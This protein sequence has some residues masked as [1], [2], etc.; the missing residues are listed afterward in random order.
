MEKKEKNKNLV[1]ERYDV[2]GMSCAACELAVQKAVKKQGVDD[3]EVSLMTNSMEVRYDPTKISS[4]MIEKAVKDAGYEASLQSLPQPFKNASSKEKE[5]SIFAEQKE[6]IESRLRLSVPFLFV[7]MYFSMGSMIGFPIPSWMQ[8]PEGSSSFALIQL[9]LTLP[10]L[11]VNRVFFVRGFSALFHRAPN[12]DSLIAL[13]ASAASLYG[14]FALF[15]INYGLGFG[16][17]EIVHTYM[18]ELYFEGA[19]MICTL[20]TVGKYLEV[21]SKMKTSSSLEALMGLRPDT[22]RRVVE[23]TEKEVPV[24]MIQVGDILSVK[25]GERI[26]LDG[27]IIQGQ[28]SV[29]ESALTGESLPVFK[30]EGD[31]VTGATMNQSGSFLFRTEAVGE[32]TAL[33]K[34]IELVREANSSKAPIQSLADQIAGIFVPAVMAISLITFFSWILSGAAF[35]FAL[36]LAISVLVISC[37]CA[38]GLATPVVVMAAT[39]KGAENGLLIKSAGALQELYQVDGFVFDKTGTLTE[40]RP[41]LTDLILFDP[42]WTADDFLKALFSLE[43]NS[44]QPLAEAIVRAGEKK[45]IQALSVEN[46]LSL[47]GRGVQGE[48]LWPSLDREKRLFLLGGNRRLMEENAIDLSQAEKTASLLAEEGKTPMYFA[49]EGELIGLAAAADQVKNTSKKALEDL[50]ER[51]VKTLMLTGDNE[52]TAKAI[53]ESL[54]LT[55]FRAEV[56]PQDKD[57]TIRALQES[58]SSGKG[59]EKWAMVGDGINDAPALSRARVGIAI[60][61]GTDVAMDSA[62]LV[63]VRSDLQDVVAAYDLSKETMRKIKQNYF[64]AFFYNV[65]CIPVAAGLFYPKFGL[66]LNP[67]IAAGAMSLSSLFVVSNAL[68]LRSFHFDRSASYQ[69][70]EGDSGTWQVKYWVKEGTKKNE[71][72]EQNVKKP[73]Q[74]NREK[75]QER[76]KRMEKTLKIEGMMCGHCKLNVEKA[77]NEMDGVQAQVDLEGGKAHVKADHEILEEDFKK[78][79]DQAGYKMTGFVE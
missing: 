56:L 67:M 61:A 33:S 8:G 40:G 3:C 66:S 53:A 59:P 55:D 21:R 12:M 39:G 15:R 41:F 50:R 76:K 34:I 7:L 37:P 29:D 11:F 65:I 27:V 25:P 38:L 36:R 64:W 68:H 10:I 18:H 63:L 22:A 75:I 6:E 57:A 5:K 1:R 74:K 46:F 49:A 52:K 47:P 78:V 62:D 9:L 51:G 69:A 20:I 4:A 54:D 13:G 71:G 24:E 14:I 48:L 58:G 43:K 79:I 44:E 26:P 31:P 17:P 60:G 2:R 28:S 73:G 32:D 19:A 30:K 72:Q 16:H 42:S 70:R 77:L 35:E 45:K 23:G